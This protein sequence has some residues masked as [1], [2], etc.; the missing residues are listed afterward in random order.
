MCE[1]QTQGG[2]RQNSIKIIFPG[3]LISNNHYQIKTFVKC[4]SCSFFFFLK[5]GST[6]EAKSN[7]QRKN[8]FLSK[9]YIQRASIDDYKMF[10]PF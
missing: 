9:T 8:M 2:R 1:E 5:N 3:D 10:E 7:K 6:K 4:P